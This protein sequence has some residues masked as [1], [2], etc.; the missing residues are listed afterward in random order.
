M[1]MGLAGKRVLVTGSTKGIGRAIAVAF[2]K[3]GADVVINGRRTDTVAAVV[4]ELAA[5]YPTTHPVAAPYDISDPQQ[6]DKMFQQGRLQE[7]TRNAFQSGEYSNGGQ[8]YTQLLLDLS[9]LFINGNFLNQHS[10]N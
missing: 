1:E 3:E 9:L 8:G 10:N 7:I 6:A 5:A 2:A 4:D